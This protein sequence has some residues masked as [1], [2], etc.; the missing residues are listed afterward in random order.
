[1]SDDQV[2]LRA[3]DGARSPSDMWWKITVFG[4]LV[5][6]CYMTKQ[7]IGFRPDHAFLSLLIFVFI[8]FGR[9][10]GR[11]FLID[12]SPFII[13]W[14]C[15]DMMRGIADNIR[16]EIN[17]EGPYELE[18]FL[19]DWMTGGDIPA[20]YLQHF[21]TLY[22]GTFIKY[23]LDF[24]S[25]LVYG[26]HF[27]SPL[28]VGWLFWHTLNERRSFY[29]FVT[30]LTLMNAA[31][32]ATFMLYPAAPPWYV[33]KYG[34]AQPSAGLLDS[35]GGLVNFDRLIGEDFFLR[36]YGTFNANR[37]A[38]IPSL[39]GGYP[40]LIALCL[41][42]R[43]GGWTWLIVIYPVCT[44]FAAV[45]LNHHYIIDLIFGALYAVGALILART[46]VL[47]QVLDRL[48]DYERTSRLLLEQAR[49]T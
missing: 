34:F 47:P 13:F 38:A 49:K 16:G 39:H 9:A 3:P 21:Q 46:L 6:Y 24:M 28:L 42:L 15:Y 11:L 18:K 17:I 30:S 12:W 36:L 25:G 5:L 19:F 45:Y 10:W 26:M 20:F 37:F 31:A 40:I 22:D 43:F 29:L 41:G 35:A 33:E 14:V 27:I 1:M 32:L 7:V 8:V 2:P 23:V 48:I 4:V 44:W